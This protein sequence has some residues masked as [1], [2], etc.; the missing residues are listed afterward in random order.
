[1][2][3]I[4]THQNAVYD[5][6]IKE[7]VDGCFDGYN[8]TVLAYG[9]TGSGKTYTMGTGFDM[10]GDCGQRGIIPRAIQHLYNGVD[11][12][13]QKA[14]ETNRP[15]PDFKI[16]IQFL[17]LYNEEIIDLLNDDRTAKNTHIKIHEDPS[18]G[19]YTVGATSRLA[20]CTETVFQLLK[21]GALSRQTG[22]TKMN[23][24][25]SRSHAIFTITVKQQRISCWTENPDNEIMAEPELE[26]LCAKF[27]F[28]DLAGSERL[29]RTGA[30]G[31]RAKEG[32]SINSGLLALGNVISALGDRTKRAQHVPYRD[33][34]LTRLLQDSL[35]GN[36]RTLMIACISPSDRDFMETLSTLRYANRAKN[37]RNKVLA[38]QDKSSQTITL[39]R[40]QIAELEIE[41]QEYR[42]GKRI[43]NTDGT[44]QIND[45]YHENRLLKAELSNIKTRLKALQDTHDRILVS[46]AELL[47]QKELSDWSNASEVNKDMSEVVKKYFQEIEELRSKLIE[48]EETCA[49][50]RKQLHKQNRL[51]LSMSPYM[52]RPTQ[53][54]KFDVQ[55]EQTD[56][57]ILHKA[58][59][60]VNELKRKLQNCAAQKSH[61]SGDPETNEEECEDCED[62][63]DEVQDEESNHSGGDSD[64]E[65]CEPELELANL[66]NEI[67]FKER[68]IS[69]LEKSQQK[70]DQI[71]QNY[72]DRLKDFQE[73]YVHIENERDQVLSKLST[74][75]DK[76]NSAESATKI[77]DKYE[78]KL[79]KLRDDIRKLQAM[80]RQHEEKTKTHYE[81]K[82]RNLKCNVEDLKK[83][84]VRL[85]NQMKEE[86]MRHR[87]NDRIKTKT[88]LQLTKQ[89]R[90]KDVKIRNLEKETDRYRSLLKRKDDEMLHLKKKIRPI[91]QKNPGRTVSARTHAN[92]A[93][94]ANITI[95]KIQANVL[96]FSPIQVKQKWLQ[97]QQTI[98]KII[99]DK[100]KI[101]AQEH[102][103]ERYLVQREELCSQLDK[104]HRKYELALQSN[105]NEAV[106]RELQEEIDNYEANIKYLNQNLNECQSL[107][108]T[109][110]EQKE[111]LENVD[112]RSFLSCGVDEMKYLFEKLLHFALHNGMVAQQK[113][114]ERR[115]FELKCK[116]MA[117]SSMIQ[118]DFFQQFFAT[119]L[120]PS[121]SGTVDSKEDDET[122][123]VKMEMGSPGAKENAQPMVDSI[124]TFG[125]VPPVLLEEPNHLAE[126]EE[127]I[128][129]FEQLSRNQDRP[130][131]EVLRTSNAPNQ[132]NVSASRLRRMTMTPI[133]VEES[134][135]MDDKM[136]QSLCGQ[137]DTG[138]L[139]RPISR[140]PSAPTLKYVFHCL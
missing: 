92:H 43:V 97:L 33:S 62:D 22:S 75:S 84:K 65:P 130:A 68:L 11:E 4:Q 73:R 44:E 111:E 30:T 83:Q 99:L 8:A 124:T 29:K 66:A 67:L 128:A 47:A 71:R 10:I 17:E 126:A 19:I 93:R 31:E 134:M 102:Q 60:E 105:Q 80:R 94:L 1:V 72:E 101:A 104:A 110:E 34:K 123:P 133:E 69:E 127:H 116:Q 53:Y 78:K 121:E 15:V 27:H 3:D 86:N 58:K 79:A 91:S 74:E 108:M 23:L 16:S 61:D 45:M 140:V 139:E 25:S 109:I 103:M 42:Q 112:F 120:F 41:L 50:Y 21:K 129:R 9:Q 113:E 7:L 20:T 26:T 95:T 63:L 98:S 14:Q 137:A 56:E 119:D 106:V 48:T 51:S 115:E 70:I 57:D 82:L 118:E 131:T 18:G 90:V 76:S 122:A 5:N 36:S 85:V 64:D 55:C 24:Q 37:I 12:R 87:E 81:G 117:N 6:C 88:I 32:I 13:V 77:C 49:Q 114:E 96:H 136:T 100:Q 107:I 52:N 125:T 38:N 39:L 132:M 135:L 54:T 89:E 59:E 28:V 46:N 35:G 40:K 138:S 2:F